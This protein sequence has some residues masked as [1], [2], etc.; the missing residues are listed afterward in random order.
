MTVTSMI[1]KTIDGVIES[2]YRQL[3]NKWIL[4]W[5]FIFHFVDINSS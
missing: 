2:K 4:L 1:Y 5:S 3:V